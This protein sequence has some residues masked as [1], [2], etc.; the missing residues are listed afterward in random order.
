M[1]NNFSKL[2]VEPRLINKIHWIAKTPI[3]PKIKEEFAIISTLSQESAIPTPTMNH[4]NNEKNMP[5]NV[6]DF[7]QLKLEESRLA[8]AL[9]KTNEQLE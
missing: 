2:S 3:H 7:N 4:A 1:R 9:R 6:D 8:A 5:I